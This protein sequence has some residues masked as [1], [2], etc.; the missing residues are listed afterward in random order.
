MPGDTTELLE[1]LNGFAGNRLTSEVSVRN[2][3]RGA[4]GDDV[5]IGRSVADLLDGGLGDDIFYVT[6]RNSIKVITGGGSDMVV[7]SEASAN[8][9]E[10]ITID[11][12]SDE[13]TL[14]FYNPDTF[15]FLDV[16]FNLART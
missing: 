9:N 4:D 7:I 8:V 2:D 14:R 16:P 5:L 11:D 13:D 6:P 12:L 3:I 15:M 10:L 1:G